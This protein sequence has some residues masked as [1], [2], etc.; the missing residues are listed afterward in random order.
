MCEGIHWENPPTINFKSLDDISENTDEIEDSSF[1][2]S[3]QQ[4]QYNINKK[5]KDFFRD[6]RQLLNIYKNKHLHFYEECHSSDLLNGFLWECRIKNLHKRI[7]EQNIDSLQNFIETLDSDSL[8]LIKCLCD[9]D[10]QQHAYNFYPGLNELKINYEINNKLP[11]NNIE[12]HQNRKSLFY[13]NFYFKPGKQ[14]R[15]NSQDTFHFH[16]SYFFDS[17]YIYNDKQNI[18]GTNFAECNHGRNA[19]TVC[20]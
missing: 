16:P 17:F 4:S 9:I 3:G 2:I 5:E 6:L 12:T 1:I 13:G 20:I 15:S 19:I 18:Y 11:E 10:P 8:N 7:Y 14:P